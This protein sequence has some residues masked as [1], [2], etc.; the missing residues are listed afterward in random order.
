VDDLDRVYGEALRAHVVSGGEAGLARAYEI[1]RRAIDEDLGVLD[2]VQAHVRAAREVLAAGVIDLETTVE[3]STEF[4]LEAVAPFELTHR[5]YRAVNHRLE[6]ANRELRRSNA[7]LEGFGHVIGHDLQQPLMAAA[8]H[9]YALSRRMEAAG[10]GDALAMAARASESVQRARSMLVGL[11]QYARAGSA[12]E[13]A[14][15]VDL[16]GLV[17]EI[18][19]ELGAARG[20]AEAVVAVGELPVLRAPR[21]QLRHVLQ[22]L[23]DNA[24]KYSADPPRVEVSAERGPEAWVLSVSD[25]GIGVPPA[26]RERIFEIF[27]RAD[28]TRPGFGVGLAVCRRVLERIGGR[29]W[30]EPGAGGG[31]VFRFTLPET[32]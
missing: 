25:H 20:F 27:R 29:I 30:V 11:L 8:S 4:A 24:V 12:G 18:I 31:A 5:G 16:A 32:A 22:N 21:E 17:A 28:E 23:I 14:V 9:L 10:D 13:P 6:A 3:R 15:T 19:A 7:D 26:D 1:A 2:L